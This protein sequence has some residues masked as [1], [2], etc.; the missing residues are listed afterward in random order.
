MGGAEL[1][2]LK[3]IGMITQ[4]AETVSEHSPRT[5]IKCRIHTPL[6]NR[7]AQKGTPLTVESA[8][9]RWG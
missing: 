4:R 8:T 9:F 5:P 2:A 1:R 7:P 6:S 3:G